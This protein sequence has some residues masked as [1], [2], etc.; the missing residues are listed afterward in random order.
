MPSY[1]LS[2]ENGTQ[3]ITSNQGG[4]RHHD[5]AIRVNGGAIAG[6]LTLT[7]RKPGSTIFESITDGV[8]DLAALS[9]IQFDGAVTEYK[10]VI[11]GMSGVLSIYLTDTARN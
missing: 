1:T 8:F 10:V 11:S 2:A 4:E 3:N 6:T 5:V 7:A 9:T